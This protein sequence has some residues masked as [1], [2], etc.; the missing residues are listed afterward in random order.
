M[1]CG[2][3]RCLQS[4]LVVVREIVLGLAHAPSLL[5]SDE[6]QPDADMGIACLT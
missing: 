2:A 4:T 1:C 5:M 6:S 3:A